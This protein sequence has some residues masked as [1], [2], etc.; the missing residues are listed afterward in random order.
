MTVAYQTARTILEESPTEAWRTIFNALW[1]VLAQPISR[2]SPD[3]EVVRRDREITELDLLI[4]RSAWELW[5]NYEQFVPRTSQTLVDFWNHTEA[6]K[7]VLILDGLSLREVPWLLEEA[8]KREYKI[9]ESGVRGAELPGETTPFARSLGFSQRSSLEN[10]GAGSA[11][12]LAGAVTDSTNLPWKDCADLIGPHERLVL[13]HHWPDERMHELAEPGHGL[14]KL[15]KESFETLTSSDFWNLV[16]R[17]TTGRRLI[18]TSDH[19]YAASGL[20]PDVKANSQT[21]YLKKVFKSGRFAKYEGEQASWVP[22]IELRLSTSHGPY[23]FV[24][25]RRKWKSAGGYPTLTHGGLSL[26]EIAVPYI[27][28]S[29]QQKGT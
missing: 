21:E 8:D 14:A 24:L 10:N 19:G 5:E 7:A 9:H 13:W 1:A 16:D 17:L 2:K 4:G 26:L 15:A 18:I 23:H 6:G 22:P 29:R 25:G 28:L 12:K 27:E 11:H 20:F 3:T